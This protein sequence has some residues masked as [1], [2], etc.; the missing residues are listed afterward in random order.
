[1]RRIRREARRQQ[2]FIRYTT[3]EASLVVREERAFLPDGTVYSLK[4]AWLADPLTPLTHD[5]ATET[6]RQFEIGVG[7]GPEK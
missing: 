1:M 7:R 3:R 6:I 2:P 5:V 4:T